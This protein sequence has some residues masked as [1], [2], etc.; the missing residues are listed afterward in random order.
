[1][2]LAME[3]VLVQWMSRCACLCACVN[4]CAKLSMMRETSFPRTSSFS[5]FSRVVNVESEFCLIWTSRLSRGHVVTVNK[6][7]GSRFRVWDTLF[8]LPAREKK[9]K[10]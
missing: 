9:L 1:M 2:G 10:C 5:I 7:L 4:F 3:D 6:Q 8:I